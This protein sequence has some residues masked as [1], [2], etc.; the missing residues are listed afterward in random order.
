MNPLNAAAALMS[1]LTYAQ[2]FLLLGLVLL[3]PAGFA[4]KAYWGVQSDTLAFARS[5]RAGV[6]FVAP[7]NELAVRVVAA[8]SAAVRAAAGDSG[9]VSGTVAA[10]KAAVAAV[11]AVDGS[12]IGTDGTWKQ[13][14]ATI[15]A[16]ATTKVAASPHAAYDGYEKASA[17]ALAAV[18]KAGDGSKLILDPDLDSYY[19]MDALITKLPALADWTGRVADLQ[20]IGSGA[21]DDRVELASAQGALKST[22]AAMTGGFTTAFDETAS[23]ALKPSLAGPLKPFAGQPSL[24]AVGALARASAPQLDALLVARMHKY[25]AARDHIALIVLFGG[26]VAVF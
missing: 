13:A 18:V 5:E 22:Q 3:A 15:L 16:A 8:R 9:D 7:A 14:R 4:L 24:P 26:F 6:R 20:V 2:K 17:A 19:V 21:L 25:S 1:R 12:A 11:D 23:T 10:V